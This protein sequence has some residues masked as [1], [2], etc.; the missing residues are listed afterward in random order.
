MTP[1]PVDTPHNR[2]V[3]G[4]GDTTLQ[5]VTPCDGGLLGCLAWN[6]TNRI[7]E[8]DEYNILWSHVGMILPRH[9]Q[10]RDLKFSAQN[11]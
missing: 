3:N 1:I 8:K 6:S 4:M 7:D 9:K 5:W 2:T 11:G 10:V